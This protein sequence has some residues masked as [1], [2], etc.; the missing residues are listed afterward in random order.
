MNIIR[1][2]F[3]ITF[4]FILFYF[5]LIFGMLAHSQTS[6]GS[7]GGG[8]TLKVATATCSTSSCSTTATCP[9]PTSVIIMSLCSG[10]D[11]G[12]IYSNGSTFFSTTYNPFNIQNSTGG[13]SN[14][15]CVDQSSCTC[16]AAS[17]FAGV[18]ILCVN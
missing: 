17:T 5:G 3:L 14:S 8:S 9:S 11:L 4:L 12:A 6:G 13:V 10:R 2:I 16:G 1:H 15:N 7:T 18:Y